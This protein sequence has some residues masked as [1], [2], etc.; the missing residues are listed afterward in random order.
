MQKNHYQIML[1]SD[2][3]GQPLNPRSYT[4]KNALWWVGK[5][6]QEFGGQRETYYEENPVKENGEYSR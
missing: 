2:T 5:A 3:A 1:R 4:E 6:N